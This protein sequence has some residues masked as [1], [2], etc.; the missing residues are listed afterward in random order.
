[1]TSLAIPPL[2]WLMSWYQSRCDGDWEHQHGVR[3]GTLDNP[4]W[5]LDVDLAE[6]PYAGRSLPRKMIERSEDDWVSVEVTGDCFR[7]DGG[8]GNLS[9]MIEMFAAFVEGRPVA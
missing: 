7:A 3:I 5:T 8:P 4:G 9:E 1:M 6:T 2:E